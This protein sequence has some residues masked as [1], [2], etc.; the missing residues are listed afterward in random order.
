MTATAKFM[1]DVDFGSA[2]KAVQPTISATQH[3]A[4]VAEAEMRGYRNGM[5]A[6]EAQA[7]T[8]AERRLAGAF[9]H[10]ASGLDQLRGSLKIVEDRFEAEAVEVAL[11]VG[12]KLA[13]TLISLEPFAEA[14]A[15]ADNCFRELLAAPHIVVRVNGALYTAAKTKLEEIAQAR[16]FEGRLVVMAESDI[17]PGD[18]RIEWADGGLKRDRAATERAISEAVERYVASRR[19][20]P[21]MP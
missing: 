10:I 9:E 16:G 12:K 2:P 14:A 18:C 6:A 7:R 20:G 19:G 1:F 4:E 5:N 15:L 11:A 21:V 17:E 13:A 8:E 3:E